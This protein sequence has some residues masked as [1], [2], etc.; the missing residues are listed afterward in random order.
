MQFSNQNGKPVTIAVGGCVYRRHTIQTHFVQIGEDYLDL[1]SR[2]VCP[3]FEEGDILS[4]SEKVIALCQGR[5]V[6][7]EELPVGFWAK[8]LSHFASE[9]THGV[10]VNNPYKMAYCIR[11]V[12]LPKT[13]FAAVC[14]AF[15]KLFGKHGVFYKIV[16]EEVA[17]LDGFYPDVF[18][19]YGEFGIENPDKPFDV[20][21]E[22]ERQLGLPCM[23]VD[24]NDLGQVLLGYSDKLREDY[25]EYELLGMIR[26]NPA[27]QG[28]RC[29]PFVL[30]RKSPLP[31][32]D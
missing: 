27:G 32:A 31:Y 3:L 9:S 1:L 10:G 17:G 15:G 11:K 29:T 23:I 2:Y 14:S 8:F 28:N 6:R 4:I 16:G 30:I 13:L 22:I 26:D 7:K 5:I 21:N 25:T 24:A 18:P 12:G 20:C 19:V